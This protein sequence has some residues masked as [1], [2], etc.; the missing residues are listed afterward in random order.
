MA[1]HLTHWKKLT[2]PD[3]IGAYEVLT[4]GHDLVLTIK[5]IKNE[6]VTGEGGKKEE[7]TVAHF[8]EPVKPMIL[9]KTNLKSIQN[10]YEDPFI[11]HWIGKKIQIFAAKVKFGKETV[12]GLRIRPTIPEEPKQA[13]HIC[14]DCGNTVQPIGSYTAEQIALTNKKTY[15][16]ILCGNCSKKRKETVRNEADGK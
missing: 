2:N 4:V 10:L 13:N 9:N 6:M 11:E 1:E 5:S 14:T 7:C 12:D 16:V 15:G 3:Y 8:A